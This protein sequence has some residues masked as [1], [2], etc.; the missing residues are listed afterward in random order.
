MK[1]VSG[2]ST[3][4]AL[5][6]AYPGSAVAERRPATG[7]RPELACPSAESAR[8]AL[9]LVAIFGLFGI[10]AAVAALVFAYHG[11]LITIAG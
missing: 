3:P 6:V 1:T 5:V 7:L 8:L 11:I 4:Q 2:S 10:V 9:F